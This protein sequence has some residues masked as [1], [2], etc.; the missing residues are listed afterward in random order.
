MAPEILTLGDKGYSFPIDVWAFGIMICEIVSG[1]SPFY[2]IDDPIKLYEKILAGNYSLPR[3]FSRSL[4]HLVQSC[5]N[6]DPD[7]RPKFTA[8]KRFDWF[9]EISW[10]LVENRTND[11]PFS[12]PTLPLG[13]VRNECFPRF[14]AGDITSV[15]G[16][17]TQFT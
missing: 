15:P 3:Y 16:H 13:E 14:D 7:F 11:T 9:S 17:S 8:L 6:V 5:L 1:Q 10:S 12:P 2:H 4:K